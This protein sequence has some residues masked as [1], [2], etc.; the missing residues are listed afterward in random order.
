M[1]IITTI[2]TPASDAQDDFG[3]F[4]QKIDTF[5]NTTLMRQINLR[6]GRKRTGGL[7]FKGQKELRILQARLDRK[8]RAARRIYFLYDVMRVSEDEIEQIHR[9]FEQNDSETAYEIV[10]TS[11]S[12]SANVADFLLQENVEDEVDMLIGSIEK[13]ILNKCSHKTCLEKALAGEY[14][15]I[16]AEGDNV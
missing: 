16:R 11:Y 3:V 9:V 8:K 7:S 6:L 15:F 12:V 10:S 1:N 2:Q 5:S 13:D 4:K 14:P